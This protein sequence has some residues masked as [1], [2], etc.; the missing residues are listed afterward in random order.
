M[1]SKDKQNPSFPYLER[2]S[3]KTCITKQWTPQLREQL[4]ELEKIAEWN[5]MR[6]LQWASEET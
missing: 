1:K 2:A 3:Q 5:G 4:S 6:S